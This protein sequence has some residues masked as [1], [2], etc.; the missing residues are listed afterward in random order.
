MT[1]FD[2]GETR[3]PAVLAVVLDEHMRVVA[4]VGRPD[5]RAEPAHDRDTAERLVNGSGPDAQH[6]LREIGKALRGVRVTFSTV[7]NGRRVRCM[8]EPM[9]VTGGTATHLLVMVHDGSTADSGDGPVRDRGAH[10]DDSDREVLTEL[11]AGKTQLSIASSLQ[12]TRRGL[13]HRVARLRRNLGES[14]LTLTGL[15]ASTYAAG[16]LVSGVWPPRT[17]DQLD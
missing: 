3:A 17:R 11:A 15:V 2:H 6:R 12:L 14:S 7:L 4:A 16:I 10:L 8:A 9:S 5:Q 13:D 1:M